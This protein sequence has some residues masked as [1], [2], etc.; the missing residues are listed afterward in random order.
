MSDLSNTTVNSENIFYTIFNKSN[1]L[2]LIWFLAIYLIIYFILGIFSRQDGQSNTKMMSSRVFDL[3]IFVF[4]VFSFGYNFLTSSDTEKEH[5]LKSVFTSFKNYISDPYS[6]FSLSLFIFVFYTAVFLVGIPMTYDTKPFSINLLESGA[7]ILFIIILLVNFCK[8]VLNIDIVELFSS[9][10]NDQWNTLPTEST[11]ILDLSNNI[12]PVAASKPEVFNIANNLYT[13]DDAHAICQSY[14]ARLATYDDVE[15]A[16]NDG[17]EWC[18]YGWSDNQMIFFPTQ[19]STW[20]QLQNDPKHANDCGRPG[21]NG[22]FIQ[23]PYI[24]FGVN[25]FGTK[26]KASANDLAMMS[27]HKTQVVPKSPEDTLLDQ[28]VKFWKENSDKL[29]HVNSF[30][31]NKWSETG[32]N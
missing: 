10:F 24:K 11:N 1:I 13:Y 6:M 32:L 12:G 22:G 14:G 8:Y 18:N 27:A 4:V 15:K 9:L 2:F 31:L 7:W 29:L 19:K 28:K 3:L 25:C 21:I 26:P 5:Q 30:N 17:G 23:N 16:Y 20:Q